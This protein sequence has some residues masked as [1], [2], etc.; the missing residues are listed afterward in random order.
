[1]SWLSGFAMATVGGALGE[2]NAKEYKWDPEKKDFTTKEQ[3]DAAAAALQA[4]LD[5]ERKLAEQRNQMD[6]DI[7]KARRIA[8]NES[9]QKMVDEAPI[10]G[11]L[12]SQQ[13]TAKEAYG[14]TAQI[15]VDRKNLKLVINPLPLTDEKA[16]ARVKALNS[17]G[18]AG[19]KIGVYFYKNYNAEGQPIIEKGDLQTGYGSAASAQAAGERDI[20]KLGVD[21]WD[22]ELT[23]KDGRYF[24]E[25]SK[26]KTFRTRQDAEAD[27]KAE[28]ANLANTGL[29][30]VVESSVDADGNTKF[31]TVVRSLPKEKDDKDARDPLLEDPNKN[32]YGGMRTYYHRKELGKDRGKFG[33]ELNEI[34]ILREGGLP[35]YSYSWDPSD[36]NAVRPEEMQYGTDFVFRAIPDQSEGN[37]EKAVRGLELTYTPQVVRRIL[38]MRESTDAKTRQIGEREFIKMINASRAVAKQWSTSSS[39]SEQVEGRG[40]T[41]YNL[42]LASPWFGQV[43]EM[44]P[45]IRKEFKDDRTLRTAI[46]ETQQ[47]DRTSLSTFAVPRE[48]GDLF[49][50]EF[51]NIPQSN[52]TGIQADDSTTDRAVNPQFTDAIEQAVEGTEVQAYD[53][54]YAID[55][56]RVSNESGTGTTQGPVAVD[57]AVQGYYNLRRAL[58][59]KNTATG[60]PKFSFVQTVEGQSVIQAPDLG[61]GTKLQIASYLAPFATITD[62]ITVMQASLPPLLREQA[63]S[64][65]IVGDQIGPEKLYVALTGNTPEEYKALGQK[66]SVAGRLKSATSAGVQLIDEGAELGFESSVTVV[67]NFFNRVGD[68]FTSSES[69]VGK[70]FIDQQTGRTIFEDQVAQDR[71]MGR[72]EELRRQ[73]NDQGLSEDRRKDALLKYH[74]S[75][76][77]YTYASMLDP[78]GRLSDRDIIQAEQSIAA[79]GLIADPKIVAEVLVEM[80]EAAAKQQA[81]SEKYK[82]G[83]P[84]T[85]L[86]AHMVQKVHNQEAVSLQD[87]LAKYS[88]RYQTSIETRTGGMSIEERNEALRG[89]GRNIEGQVDETIIGAD[90]F[91]GQDA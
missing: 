69:R 68:V 31:T 77:A 55:T 22:Y 15:Y 52:T 35:G 53:L 11:T 43:A 38:Q 46:T 89:F 73:A 79:F 21:Q 51:Q 7:E 24:L 45:D 91:A 1:M 66:A 29:R 34:I 54:L 10:L 84:R 61:T 40:R 58:N 42:S 48:N 78:N 82:T 41:F 12:Y 2:W 20:K 23:T 62:Q 60:E 44:H 57:R 9:L 28:N 75:I 17:T 4:K 6:I 50:P 56:A 47:N 72:L 83:R 13:A 26:K 27:A 65:Q 87:L 32:A 19:D 36:E 71:A 25:Y 39:G 18:G 59:E 49:V 85:I 76:A 5:H 33:N 80:H 88:N 16:D 67:Q 14:D 37:E 63:D 86:A 3:R 64:Y 8:K 70:L 30:A 74:L 90:G 81:Y